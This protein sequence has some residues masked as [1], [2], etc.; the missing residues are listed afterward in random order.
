ME[1]QDAKLLKQKQRK[2]KMKYGSVAVAIT[3]IVT[4]IVILLNVVVGLLVER[5]PNAKLDLTTSNLYEVSDETIDYIKNL[6]DPVEIAVSSE[7]STLEKDSYLKM[8]TEM[9]KKYQSYSSEVEITYFDTTK[10]PDILSKYQ[11]KYSGTISSD[12]VIVCSGDRVRVFPLSDFFEMDQNKLQYYY[13]GQATLAECITAFKGEQSLTNAIMNVTDANPQRVGFIGTSNGNS[14]YNPTNGNVYAAQVL[15]TLLDDNGYDVTQ[16]DMVTDEIS[17]EDY[18][19]LV[20]PAP[21]NDLTVDAIE[22]LETFL[23]NDGNLG[24]RLLYIA[25]FTQGNTPNLDAFLKDWNIVVD[26][27][28][29]IDDNAATQ[30]AVTLLVAGNQR[31]YTPIVTQV[32]SDYSSGLANTS[33]PIVAPI[34]RPILTRDANNGRVVTNLLT[35]ADTSYCV[36]LNLD[37]N[38]EKAESAWDAANGVEQATEAATEETTEETTTTSFDVA[39]AERSSYSV[40]AFSQNQVSQDNALLESDV[41]VIGSMGY[42]DVYVAQ[43]TSYNNAEYFISALN[44][45]CGKSDNIVI[46]SKNMNLTSMDVTASQMKMVTTVVILVIPAIMVVIG[47]VIWARRKSR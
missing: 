20:L 13:Y 34:S 9:L 12:N 7:E 15:S 45:I 46:A 8:V 47:I 24:K 37:G 5:Y 2:K 25:D 40:M 36:P 1:Q 14:I 31:M 19:L 26:T 16:L 35:T 33:L 38:A 29:V 42:F 43:D 22:K 17:A 4:A 27:S 30:Q 21:V 44:T 28:Y 18:D 32:S 39:N 10:N 41:M 11:S 6:E 23:H 3:L